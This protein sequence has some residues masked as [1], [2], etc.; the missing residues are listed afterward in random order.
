MN[1]SARAWMAAAVMEG[2]DPDVLAA[3]TAPG[4]G[5]AIWRREPA[6]GFLAWIGEQ[7]TFRLRTLAT[8]GSIEVVVQAAGD[9]SG[10]PPNPERDRLASDI[11]ALATILWRIA[12][13]PLISVQLGPADVP[14]DRLTHPE[15][16]AYRLLCAYLGPG[17]RLGP[18]PGATE[19]RGEVLRP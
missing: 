3:V 8:P 17:L 15:R 6:Q 9:A 4:V 19:L 16:A 12:P 14:A 18:V 5:A 10:I 13:T 1:V 2:R 11:A 7:P